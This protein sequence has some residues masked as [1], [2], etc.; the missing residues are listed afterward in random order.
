MPGPIASLDRKYKR[1][2][3]QD[4]YSNLAVL[5]KS[6]ERLTIDGCL[7]RDGHLE[8]VM[9]EN[10]MLVLAVLCALLMAATT[11]TGCS[12]ADK[13]RTE[14]SELKKS[15][16][17]KDSTPKNYSLFKK[18]EI[19]PRILRRGQKVMASPALDSY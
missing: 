15:K 14:A 5:L 8:E 10:R 12:S 1:R 2:T 3:L 4:F 17:K 11:M 13:Q 6:L 18:G 16:K 19:N 9:N 7:S